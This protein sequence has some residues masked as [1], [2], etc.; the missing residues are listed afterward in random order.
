MVSCRNYTFLQ[1][2]S[3]IYFHM[4]YIRAAGIG[5]QSIAL[6]GVVEMKIGLI[7][8][9]KVGFSLGRYF[10]ENQIPV[11]GYCSRSS[12]SAREAANFTGTAWFTELQDLVERSDILF[13]TTS[14]AAIDDVWAQ[15]QNLP[16]E[17]KII[18]HCSGSLSSGIFSEIQKRKA[19]GYSVHPLL[20]ISSK[21][22]GYQLMQDAVFAIEGDD[23]DLETMVS[24]F[25]RLGN[26]VQTIS[27]E[28][29]TLYHCAAVTVSNHVLALLDSG[30]SML[31]QCGFDRDAARNALAPL[32][33][34][35]V[36]SALR[37][38]VVQ[39]LTG[40]VERCD[41][42]TVS[43]HLQSLSDQPEQQMLYGLLAK[44]LTDIASVK[45][46]QR[47]YSELRTMLGD[48]FL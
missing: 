23:E 34:G 16:I 47:D 4:A 26:P 15:L 17:N 14:D 1:Q 8:A 45:H 7:G 39:S 42:E 22:T 6:K 3:T 25:R 41:Q 46:P 9:G 30:I 48:L 31:M 35:N 33:R 40:P 13:V 24:L 32:I 43:G 36:E 10:C 19:Y 44:R 29:K 12:D 20:A 38:D 37:N 27:K 28:Q 11:T 18:C 2:T 5:P 21:E